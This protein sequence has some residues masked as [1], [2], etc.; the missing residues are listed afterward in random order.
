MR[1]DT[2]Y[3]GPFVGID[4][5]PIYRPNFHDTAYWYP[6]KIDTVFV[7]QP[8][9]QRTVGDTIYVS[10]VGIFKRVIDTTWAKKIQVWLT[11]YELGILRRI[12]RDNGDTAEVLL[13]WIHND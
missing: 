3:H 7:E 2:V 8:S 10:T 1:D 9:P 13:E 4:T 12:I 5:I 6:A 11:P